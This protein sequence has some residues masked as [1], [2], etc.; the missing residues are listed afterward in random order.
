MVYGGQN[1]IQH[2]WNV[3]HS[4]IPFLFDKSLNIIEED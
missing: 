1:N 3:I 4:L 2:V